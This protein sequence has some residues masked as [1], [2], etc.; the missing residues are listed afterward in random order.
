MF[1]QKL[2]VAAALSVGMSDAMSAG[3]V[4]VIQ[5]SGNSPASIQAAVDDF[6]TAL[7]ALNSPGPGPVP[8]AGRREIN[9]DGVPD[10]FAAPNN[11]PADFFNINSPRGAVF[12]GMGGTGSFQVSGNSGVAP[13]E[14]DNINPNYSKF[15]QPFSA[16]RLFTADNNV[17]EVHFF[18]P[19]TT[20]KAWVNG[21]GAVFTDVD[22]PNTT[23]E[24]IN[25]RGVVVHKA[26]V[27]TSTSGGLS[28][29]G[30]QFQSDKIA[31]VRITAGNAVLNS[32]NNDNNSVIDLVVMDDFIYGEPRP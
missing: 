24:Y 23:I 17:L 10:G 12:V 16:Q 19:G 9:W 28:F 3:L 18:M 4:K 2:L 27:P 11:L 5:G 32:W 21:F 1:T 29:V 6:R 30:V 13:T 25:P 14:F 20:Q 8:S 22:T 15:F 7:G 26:V 31:K